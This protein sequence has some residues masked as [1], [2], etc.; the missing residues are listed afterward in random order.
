MELTID[1]KW[2]TS[3]AVTGEGWGRR[4]WELDKSAYRFGVD[5]G[6]SFLQV[7]SVNFSET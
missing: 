1:G 6:A 5:I 4:G 7:A 2:G 3:S